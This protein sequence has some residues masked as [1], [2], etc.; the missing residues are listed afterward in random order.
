M[1]VV[2]GARASQKPTRSLLGR[3]NAPGLANEL[4]AH[5]IAHAPRACWSH[6]HVALR[7]QVGQLREVPARR[8]VGALE[9]VL[10]AELRHQAEALQNVLDDLA[11]PL[12]LL[13]EPLT[14]LGRVL[15]QVLEGTP[16]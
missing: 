1:V 5:G 7:L 15:R 10:A 14:L 3:R 16:G 8:A 12:A 13:P 11:S 9:V 2:L 4:T 6:H